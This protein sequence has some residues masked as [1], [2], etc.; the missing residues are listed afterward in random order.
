MV[1]VEVGL[2]VAL[3]ELAARRDRRQRLRPDV[4]RL[5]R[6]IGIFAGIVL[7]FLAGAEVDV[8][9]L[10]GSG[11]R[12]VSIGVVSFF[13]PVRGRLAARLLA[14]RLEPRAVRDR[15]HRP[16]HHQPR[17]RLRRARRDGPQPSDR[18]QADHVGDVRD[19]LRTALA[20][21]A[22]F[23][24]PNVWI[25]PSSSVSVA[26][27]VGAAADRAVVLRPLRRP[28]DRARDQARVRRPVRADGARRRANGH[29]ALP[30]FVLGL[31]MARHYQQHRKEQE[32]LRVVAFAFLTPFF[33]LKGGLNVS[34]GA[35]SA[36]LGVLGAAARRKMVPKLGAV[37]PLARR[38]T[39]P[40]TP[41]HDPADEH[42]AHIRHDLLALRPQRGII[43]RDAVLAPV[44]VVVLSAIVPDRD[45]PAPLRAPRAAVVEP[46]AQP[47]GGQ[48][49]AR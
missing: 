37:F 42:R 29:A 3:I 38:C 41:L 46:V 44:T 14:A 26:L 28:R 9:Q 49:S 24:K 19:R 48:R 16:L 11:G 34:L 47:A 1:S 8:P 2:S 30:A 7:T 43:D 31:A 22:L 13:G 45:R 20:L 15:G 17:G 40:R 4:A 5:A 6:F 36:N 35:V 23:I 18:R 32:R 39:A 12:R 33:F 27:I 25:S 21:S 10:R